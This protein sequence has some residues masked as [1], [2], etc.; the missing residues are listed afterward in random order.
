MDVDALDAAAALPGVEDGAIDKGCRCPCQ[1]C[2]G[3]HVCRVIAAELE[4]NRHDAVRGGASNS[5]TAP[6]RPCE[7]DVP[8]LGELDDSL[9]LNSAAEVHN[10]QHVLG[11]S[12]FV[13]GLLEPLANE[14]SLRRWLQEDCVAG[15]K[16]G[17]E[18]VDGDKPG[19]LRAVTARLEY[20][21]WQAGH[22]YKETHVPSRADK[23]GPQG[24][25]A[26]P[27][28][29]AILGQPREV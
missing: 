16:G 27:S 13:K 23:D 15:E 5:E 1:V 10:L 18:G 8:D 4:I 28:L 14:W 11:E 2:V 9:K 24:L 26:H 3:A 17:R 19:K 20:I 12:S 7:A 22:T 25:L 6:C 29:E 21:L